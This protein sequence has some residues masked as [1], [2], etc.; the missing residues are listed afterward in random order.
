MGLCIIFMGGLLGGC[1]STGGARQAQNSS[2]VDGRYV[3]DNK[4]LVRYVKNTKSFNFGKKKAY[5]PSTLNVEMGVGARVSS[6]MRVDFDQSQRHLDILVL[7]G[8]K[9]CFPASVDILETREIRIRSEVYSGLLDDAASDLIVQRHQLEVL[10][11]KLESIIESGACD[12]FA[13][14]LYVKSATSSNSV[15]K[16][17]KASHNKVKETIKSTQKTKKELD[18]VQPKAVTK[19]ST[20][21]VNK[22]VEVVPPKKKIS[23]DAKS[24]QKESTESLNEKNAKVTALHKHDEHSE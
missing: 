20:N 19:K 16:K 22:N 21:K 14:S 17:E 12:P 6:L 4:G 9:K 3:T 8:A 11:N 2:G 15:V 5:H 23:V 1:S 18:V 10:E 24:H 13:K 7:K